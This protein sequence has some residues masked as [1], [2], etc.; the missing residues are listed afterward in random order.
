MIIELE[1]CL[2]DCPRQILH[3]RQEIAACCMKAASH[4]NHHDNGLVERIFLF[5]RV[6]VHL[7][8]ERICTY[9]CGNH[10]N[11]AI[12]SFVY[13]YFDLHHDNRLDS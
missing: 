2:L 1:F 5:F 9:K 11:V 4:T 8:T 6:V 10:I 3:C 12:S 7:Q 13:S